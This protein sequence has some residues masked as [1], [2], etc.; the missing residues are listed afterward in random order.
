MLNQDVQ[1]YL[2]VRRAM[3]FG[4]K[5]SGNEG[6]QRFPKQR[7]NTMSALKQQ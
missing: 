5:W 2:A 1:A 4:M 3:G 7:A 6:S